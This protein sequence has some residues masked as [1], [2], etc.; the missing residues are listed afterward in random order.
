MKGNLL[1]ELERIKALHDS[2]YLTD[3]ERDVMVEGAKKAAKG[4]FSSSVEEVPA[5]GQ[6]L[7]EI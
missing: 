6:T 7:Q 1:E 3:A 4:A 5:Q 2:G